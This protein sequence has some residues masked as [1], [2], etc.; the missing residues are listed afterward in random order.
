MVSKS[1][2]LNSGR[3]FA[4]AEGINWLGN[5]MYKLI[6][7]AA[8]A[9]A[10][11]AASTASASTMLFQ[12]DAANS[13]ISL[14]GLNPTCVNFP[15]QTGGCE[16]SAS[17]VTPFSDITLSQGQSATFNFADF[18]ITPGIIGG[19]SS[20]NVNAS[21]AFTTPDA[22][23]A[24]ATGTG[25]YGIFLGVLTAGGL[26]WTNPVQQ[27]STPDGSQFTVQFN[28]LGGFQ[29]GNDAIDTITITADSIAAAVPEPSVW[30]MLILGLGLTGAAL[31]R[32]S[33][34]IAAAAA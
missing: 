5:A 32:R 17:L 21:L 10:L 18:H 2:T 11:F 26:T 24:S 23:P 3:G 1:L 34:K 28:D 29:I 25:S 12:F 27:F 6:S 33:S 16:L 4:G 8:A 7:A 19:D 30:A 9:V 14:S 22:G 15:H 13:S 20:V 31:R